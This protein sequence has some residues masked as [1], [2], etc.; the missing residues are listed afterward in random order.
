MAAL[1]INNEN[2]AEAKIQTQPGNFSLVG[3]GLNIGKDAGQPVSKRLR[4]T[5]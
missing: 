1:Y 3:E 5:L 2:V 4:V